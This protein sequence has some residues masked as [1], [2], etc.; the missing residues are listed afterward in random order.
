MCDSG[1][2]NIFNVR[3]YKENTGRGEANLIASSEFNNVQFN[4]PIRVS[5]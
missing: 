3:T 2:Y 5:S 1:L 4:A